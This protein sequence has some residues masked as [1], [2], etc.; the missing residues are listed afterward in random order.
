V[1]QTQEA[2]EELTVERVA[3]YMLRTV[4][5]LKVGEEAAEALVA[6]PALPNSAILTGFHSLLLEEDL[7]GAAELCC[8]A[9]RMAFVEEAVVT[10]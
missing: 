7:A 4:A 1:F 10:A 5:D 2:E 8:V 3:D 6:F 9:A